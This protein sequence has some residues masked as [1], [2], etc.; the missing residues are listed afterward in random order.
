MRADD[1]A[2][3]LEELHR[4][5]ALS[6]RKPALSARGDCYNCQEP[7]SNAACFC[8]ADCREDYEKRQRAR[9]A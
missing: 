6:Q 8:D 1:V 5:A 7:V 3:E 2:T 9:H 4:T